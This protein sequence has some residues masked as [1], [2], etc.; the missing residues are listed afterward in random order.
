MLSLD[1]EHP[2]SSSG[3]SYLD[4]M[5]D[6]SMANEVFSEDGLYDDADDEWQKFVEREQRH[7]PKHKEPR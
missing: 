7:Q 2:S 6:S 3:S 1:V 5:S 4:Y